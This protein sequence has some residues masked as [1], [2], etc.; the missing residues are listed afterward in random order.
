MAVCRIAADHGRP[1]RPRGLRPLPLPGDG[2]PG[3]AGGHG[4]HARGLRD[5]RDGPVNGEELLSR[6]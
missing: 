4:A 3:K 2:L 5:R 6:W 1:H